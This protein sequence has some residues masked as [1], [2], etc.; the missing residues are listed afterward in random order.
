MRRVLMM[1]VAVL[2]AP[3]V[4]CASS[5]TPSAAA[6]LMVESPWVRTTT[7][8]KDPSMTAAFLTVV[9]PGAADVRLVSADCADA[10]MVQIHE[11]VKSGDKMMMQEAKDGAL[12]PAGGHLHLTPGGYHVMLMRLS[13]EFAVGDSVNLTLH[14]SDGS[15]LPVTAPVKDFVEE[16]DHYHSPSPTPSS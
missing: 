7:G 10:G 16:E 6:A 8:A 15:S 12:V 11:M 1:L 5:A 14:F 9:N 4:A 2:V 13:R 3:L